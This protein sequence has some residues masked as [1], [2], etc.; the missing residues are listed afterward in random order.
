MALENPCPSCGSFAHLPTSTGGAICARCRHEVALLPQPNAPVIGYPHPIGVS[1]GEEV[2][3][4]DRVYY[5]VGRLIYEQDVAATVYKWEEW[6][7]LTPDGHELYFVNYRGQWTVFEPCQPPSTDITTYYIDEGQSVSFEGG[8]G[9]V[10]DSGSCRI[11]GGEGQLPFT[12]VPGNPQGYI[13]ITYQGHIYAAEFNASGTVD[14]FRGRKEP[15]AEL[16]TVLGRHDLA[17]S[18]GKTKT[19]AGG[20]GT[21]G[22]ICIAMGLAALLIAYLMSFSTGTRVGGLSI[23]ASN[24]SPTGV[25]FGPYNLDAGSYRLHVAEDNPQGYVQGTIETADDYQLA[26][27]PPAY[28]EGAPGTMPYQRAIYWAKTD[29][30]LDHPGPVYV[31]LQSP[32]VPSGSPAQLGFTLTKSI[33]YPSLLDDFAV[34]AILVGIACLWIPK[35]VTQ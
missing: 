7:A 9:I 26:G 3:Y 31:L 34:F 15:V 17:Q 29:F 28:A 20:L 23:A 16:Y 14:W 24:M 25:V 18:A 4:G 1:I 21:F 12:V 10:G 5:L 22:W 6:L 30:R 2:H 8:T 35:M 33:W 19:A 32:A 13:N 11:I 27:S